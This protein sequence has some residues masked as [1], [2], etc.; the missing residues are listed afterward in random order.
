MA[1]WLTGWL[2]DC[3]PACLPACRSV[4]LSVWR[5]DW[6]T[7]WLA[8]CLTV[9]LSD[10]LT[11]WLSAVCPTVSLYVWLTDWLSVFQIH[12]LVSVHSYCRLNSASHISTNVK[13]METVTLS[14]NVAV[15]AASTDALIQLLGRLIPVSSTFF[16]FLCLNVS[17]WSHKTMNVEGK[18]YFEILF[19]KGWVKYRNLLDCEYRSIIWDVDSHLHNFYKSQYFVIK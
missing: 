18:L 13:M 6:L 19:R 17:S 7:D 8:D 3:L 2:T 12:D 15:M 1:N 14:K 5:T 9:W 10:W 4:C 16:Y 11:V